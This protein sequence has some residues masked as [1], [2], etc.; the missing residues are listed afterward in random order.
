[1]TDTLVLGILSLLP[2]L[3]IC[4]YVW[5]RWQP[6]GWYIG[7]RING[8]N[9]SKCM[10]LYPDN[11]EGIWGFH[12]SRPTQE[13]DYI[14]RACPS[15]DKV[16][17]IAMSCEVEGEFIQAENPA[18]PPSVSLV[19]QRRGDDWSGKPYR[20]YFPQALPLTPG[21]HSAIIRLDDPQWVS[22]LG[23]GDMHDTLRD[24][25]R[26]GL[27]FGGDHGLGHGVR[28]NT[29]ARFKLTSFIFLD[30]E[31]LQV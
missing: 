4:L 21:I 12:L 6:R 28:A 14:T 27:T 29:T 15:L 7:P 19:I 2:T 18:S 31:H 20:W 8:K 13:V 9:A 10:P 11:D 3:A 30:N 22:V 25:A 1:M 16:V 23:G 17:A 26:I 5:R 24:P